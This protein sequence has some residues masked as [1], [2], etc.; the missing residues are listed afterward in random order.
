M[1][2]GWGAQLQSNN[3]E[4]AISATK[5]REKT[6]A[7]PFVVQTTVVDVV[8]FIGVRLGHVVVWWVAIMVAGMV[9]VN[10]GGRQDY[11]WPSTGAPE[12]RA[13]CSAT[14]RVVFANHSSTRGRVPLDY[15]TIVT[16]D[17]YDSQLAHCV[18][19]FEREYAPQKHE[20]MSTRAHDR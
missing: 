5:N 20:H 16:T 9:V 4:K 14:F 8:D 6:S 7:H 2:V 10:D 11:H 17:F 13:H 12:R 3:K 1:L 15:T 19:E 18:N